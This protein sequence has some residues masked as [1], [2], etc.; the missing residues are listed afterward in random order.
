MDNLSNIVI[1]QQL[2]NQQSNNQQ[3][4]IQ[5]LN[6]QQSNVETYNETNYKHC[7]NECQKTIILNDINNSSFEKIN[8]QFDSCLNK[9]IAQKINHTSNYKY[10]H[11]LILSRR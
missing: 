8:Y 10:N 1:I 11:L 9:C 3:S 6:N 2:N 4:N 5:Q 7:S